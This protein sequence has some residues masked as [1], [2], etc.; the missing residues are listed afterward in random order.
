[1]IRFIV[2]LC[3]AMSSQLM[4]ME[5]EYIPKHD[6]LYDAGLEVLNYYNAPKDTNRFIT[7][8]V[9]G[10]RILINNMMIQDTV[11]LDVKDRHALLL[12]RAYYG[13]VQGVQLVLEKLLEQGISIDYQDT[14]GA[15]ALFAAVHAAW[16][17]SRFPLSKDSANIFE[18]KIQGQIAVVQL[19]LMHGA[20][21]MHDGF[22]QM[23]PLH[24][25]EYIPVT[26]SNIEKLKNLIKTAAMIPAGS[27]FNEYSILEPKIESM[28]IE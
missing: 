11:H 1:M 28:C 24:M 22:F 7:S 21:P 3:I 15:T 13:D 6:N 19:L 18:K 14:Q 27:I 2:I 17:A 26:S 5:T 4:T 23:T 20:D 12:E 8:E 25:S 10:E 9:S 16:N